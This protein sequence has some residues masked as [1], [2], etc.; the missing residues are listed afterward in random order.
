VEEVKELAHYELMYILKPDLGEE[1]Q[2]SA[3]EKVQQTVEGAGGTVDKSDKWGRRKLAY[4]IEDYSEGFYVV[5]NFQGDGTIANEITRLLN[6][7]E[8]VVRSIVIREDE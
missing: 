8:D 7:N 5:V 1:A 2:G 6:I 3:I 4:D